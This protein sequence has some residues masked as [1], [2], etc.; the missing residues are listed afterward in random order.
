MVQISHGFEAQLAPWLEG[1]VGWSLVFELPGHRHWYRPIDPMEGELI[2]VENSGPGSPSPAIEMEALTSS[3]VAAVS[4]GGSAPIPTE[5]RPGLPVSLR[6]VAVEIRGDARQLERFVLLNRPL[7]FTPLD[8]H[9][10]VLPPPDLNPLRGLALSSAT[11]GIIWQRPEPI[12]RGLCDIKVAGV[13]GLTPEHGEG[14]THLKGVQGLI[15][16]GFITCVDTEYH[17]HN[18]PLTAAIL[19]DAAHPGAATP[20]AIP[21]IARVQRHSGVFS[22]AG[23]H[24][25]LL[26]RRV[27]N[28]WVVV[29]GGKG[30]QQR[31]TVLEHLR[32][33]IQ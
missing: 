13:P 23:V 14:V 24:G 18:T 3:D 28:A 4:I 9:D 8:A 1:G 5:S 11:Q 22:A 20:V 27:H 31:L 26:A 7:R 29:E 21:D 17:L 16:D 25:R 32:A 12:A 19:L 15:G 2:V 30:L 6:A 10:N 33:T